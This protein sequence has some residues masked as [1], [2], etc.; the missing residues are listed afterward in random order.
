MFTFEQIKELVELVSRHRLHSLEIERAG[1]RLRLAS[2]PAPAA[3]EAAP[4]PLP[5]AVGAAAAA[6]SPA[7]GPPLAPPAP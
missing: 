1:F 3:R 7:P 2:E 6:A 4:V 5:A